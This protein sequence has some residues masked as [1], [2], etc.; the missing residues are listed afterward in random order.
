MDNGSESS[1]VVCS[2]RIRGIIQIVII[3]R[4]I[5]LVKIVYFFVESFVKGTTY[6]DSPL[7]TI[8]ISNEE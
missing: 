3:S 1:F 5:L 6:V 4:S 2:L 8:K 7:S